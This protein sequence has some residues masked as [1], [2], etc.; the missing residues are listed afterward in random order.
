MKKMTHEEKCLILICNSFD[1]ELIPITEQLMI[2]EIIAKS[3]NGHQLI[4]M[5]IEISEKLMTQQM[6][7]T[8]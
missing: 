4:G 6:V 1:D 7:C 2:V 5:L 8:H 3:L